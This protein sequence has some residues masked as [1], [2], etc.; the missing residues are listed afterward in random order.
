MPSDHPTSSQDRREREQDWPNAPEPPSGRV[1][2][3]VAC[4]ACGSPEVVEA[5]RRG[6]SGGPYGSVYYID[7]RCLSCSW[8]DIDRE[9]GI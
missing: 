1:W 3:L 5:E 6:G 9:G 7:R 8:E 2:P 4:P